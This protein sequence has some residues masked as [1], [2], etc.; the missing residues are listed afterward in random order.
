ME[1]TVERLTEIEEEL[2]SRAFLFDHPTTYR[3]A[4]EIAF[5]QMREALAREFAVA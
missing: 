2:A 1:M 3:E 5:R 4:I